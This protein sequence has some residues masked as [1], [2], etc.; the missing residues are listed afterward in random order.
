VSS[1]SVWT[2]DVAR[3]RAATNVADKPAEIL[4][5]GTAFCRRCGVTRPVSSFHHSK[6]RRQSWCKPCRRRYMH[7]RGQLHRSQSKAARERR[8]LQAREFVLDV[9]RNGRC[10]DCLLEDPLVLE[11]DHL[12]AKQADVAK[13]VHEGYALER[14]RAEV[15]KCEL[16]C[17][18]CHRRRTAQRARTWRAHLDKLNTLNRPLR[19]RNLRFLID[20]LKRSQCVDCG[21]RDILVLDF[22]HVG[23][24]RASVVGLALDEHGLASIAREIASCQVRCA[25]CHRRRTI[26]RQPDHLRR[27]C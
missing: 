22:D 3:P 11:F 8:R 25:N 26:Q 17:V 1:A 12:D 6:G 4:P 16:V 20:H 7:D 2:R 18:S 27:L 21:E 10:S 13:L 14:V 15:A 19:S 9:V 5:E 24:K 23:P